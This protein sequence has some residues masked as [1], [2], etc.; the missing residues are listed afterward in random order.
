MIDSRP[1]LPPPP[2]HRLQTAHEPLHHRPLCRESVKQEAV[3]PNVGPLRFGTGE[4]TMESLHFVQEDTRIVLQ[5]DSIQIWIDHIQGKAKKIPWWYS[6]GSFPRLKDKGKASV[7]FKEVCGGDGSHV[8]CAYMS[9]AVP[10]CSFLSYVSLCPCLCLYLCLYCYSCLRLRR[11]V[12]ACVRLCF[13]LC[14][15]CSG[16]N[17]KRP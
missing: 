12:V 1:P 15:Y 9:T 13:C 5:E 3:V 16:H 10:R 6:K 11:S 2:K 8:Q 17:L 14:L 7:A 4:S